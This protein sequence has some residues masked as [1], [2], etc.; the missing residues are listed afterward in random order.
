[1]ALFSFLA[2]LVPLNNF[3]HY[4]HWHFINISIANFI[5]ICL[6]IATFIVALLAP[7]PGRARRK[8]EK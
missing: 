1:M 3:G 6:M 5:V 8:G 2:A 4:L 7:F